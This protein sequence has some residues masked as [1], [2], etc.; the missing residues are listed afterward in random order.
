[1][2]KITF[3]LIPH[4]FEYSKPPLLPRTNNALERFIG[5][6]KKSRRHITG[7]KNTQA[8]ML[9]QGHMVA[10]R[11]GRPQTDNWGD[12]FARVDRHDFQQPLRLLRQTDKRSNGWRARHDLAAYLASLEQPW[13]P[14]E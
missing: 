5:R 4:L 12:A 10:M 11:F 7:R 13:V 8:F 3:A 2:E 9:R 6:L 14:H 1:V